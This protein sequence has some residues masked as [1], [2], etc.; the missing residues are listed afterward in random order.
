ML[1]STLFVVTSCLGSDDDEVTYYGDTAI[2]SFALGTMNRYVH[3]TSSA[4]ADSVYKT[5]YAGS[6][7]VFYIDQLTCDIYNVPSARAAARWR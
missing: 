1:L 6:G 2:T 7:Y 4:G 5:T 3:T